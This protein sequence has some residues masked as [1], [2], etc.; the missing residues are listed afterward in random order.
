MSP[1]PSRSDCQFAIVSSI[2]RSGETGRIPIIA[3]T[4]TNVTRMV[5]HMLETARKGVGMTTTE[6]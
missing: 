5:A 1:C 3:V 6:A 2:S 4:G